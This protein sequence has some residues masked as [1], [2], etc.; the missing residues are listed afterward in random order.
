MRFWSFQTTFR[1]FFQGRSSHLYIGVV[2]VLIAYLLLFIPLPSPS[3][4]PRQ[5]IQGITPGLGCLD[6]PTRQQHP[7]DTYSEAI[8]LLPRAAES[9]HVPGFCLAL[10]LGSHYSPGYL[11]DAIRVKRGVAR[12]LTRY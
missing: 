4:C 8:V 2:A 1:N 6:N 7:V 10:N 9:Y 3:S 12:L 11:E 5:H